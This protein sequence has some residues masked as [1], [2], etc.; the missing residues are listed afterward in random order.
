MSE[1]RIGA[2]VIAILGLLLLG[3]MLIIHTVLA[4]IPPGTWPSAE[5][6]AEAE[7][8]QCYFRGV[9]VAI[10][11]LGIVAVVAAAAVFLGKA[12]GRWLCIAVASGVLI[13]VAS[14]LATMTNTW[15]DYLG[16]ILLAVASFYF[17]RRSQKRA[18]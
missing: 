13:E 6:V 16:E 18:L 1:Q 9:L 4:P 3:R 7:R 15:K 8:I 12:W 2:V 10:G 14:E 5:V 17:F 11:V